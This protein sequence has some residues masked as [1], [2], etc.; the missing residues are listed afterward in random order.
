MKVDQ[1]KRNNSQKLH[2]MCIDIK[3]RSCKPGGGGG[4]HTKFARM[5][6]SKSDGHGSFLDFKMSEM[7]ES[8]STQYGFFSSQ[9][10]QNGAS[11][12]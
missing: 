9:A 1:N 11:L 8:V 3:L 5:C 10:T 7:S 4:L 2:W 6:V 12:N